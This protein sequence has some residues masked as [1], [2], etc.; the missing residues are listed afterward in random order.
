[1]VV[2]AEEH[3]TT[4]TSR[5]PKVDR[6]FPAVP[7]DLQDWTARRGSERGAVEQQS[8]RVGHEATRAARG[9]E[10]GRGHGRGRK[11]G[12]G[13]VNHGGDNTRGGL[14]GRDTLKPPRSISG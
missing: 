1:M 6:R 14:D 10:V 9:I 5:A 7:A 11:S 8:L 3:A 4:L 13:R 2:H 12:V